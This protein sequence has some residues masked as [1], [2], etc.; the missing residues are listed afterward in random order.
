MVLGY[1]RCGPF[2][3]LCRFYGFWLCGCSPFFLH[4]LYNIGCGPYAVLGYTGCGPFLKL[5]CS[6]L[7]FLVVWLRSFFTIT[8]YNIDCDP[9]TVLGYTGCGPFLKLLCSFYGFWLCGCG[10]FLQSAAVPAI[11]LYTKFL[12][13][14]IHSSPSI[15]SFSPSIHSILHL[16]L[17]SL[18]LLSPLLQLRSLRL[19]STV[20]KSTLPYYSVRLNEY[21]R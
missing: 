21:I 2:L 15:H 10:L 7:R 12:L 17:Y 14:S 4:N 20:T 8:V 18:L 5:L 13:P 6:H 19:R 9:Y 11:K 1:T 3:L 16:P